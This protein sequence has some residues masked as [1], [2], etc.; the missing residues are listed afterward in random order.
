MAVLVARCQCYTA[1]WPSRRKGNLGGNSGLEEGLGLE[2]SGP[3]ESVC[4]D[5]SVPMGDGLCRNF[6]FRVNAP[7]F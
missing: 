4:A 6:G 1:C 2:G 7:Q 5:V 3:G